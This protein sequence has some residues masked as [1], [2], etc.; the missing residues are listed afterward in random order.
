MRD[1]VDPWEQALRGHPPESPSEQV[2]SKHV[3]SSPGPT[4]ASTLSPSDQLSKA[5]KYGLNYYSTPELW[6]NS[7][8]VFALA[9]R[10]AYT[11][12]LCRAWFI[13]LAPWAGVFMLGISLSLSLAGLL[14][15]SHSTRIH[16]MSLVLDGAFN[17]TYSNFLATQSCDSPPPS[18]TFVWWFPFFTAS[19]LDPDCE[20]VA[21]CLPAIRRLIPLVQPS[22]LI[23]LHSTPLRIVS[24]RVWFESKLHQAWSSFSRFVYAVRTSTVTF[25]CDNATTLLSVYCLFPGRSVSAVL[26]QLLRSYFGQ[27]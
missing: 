25:M 20:H 8:S 19:H 24:S 9:V 12:Y 17:Q 11:Y 21:R 18:Y 10:L 5:D 6:A 2:P 7:D 3:A 1:G 26:K 13:F 16:E 4:D 14:L 15:P 22:S 23:A 27:R